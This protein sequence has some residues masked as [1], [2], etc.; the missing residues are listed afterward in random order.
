MSEP[1]DFEAPTTAAFRAWVSL[2]LSATGSKATIVSKETGASVNS[3]GQFLRDSER[4]ISLGR[5]A[6]IERHL[7]AK[8]RAEGKSL[9]PIADA[10]RLMG[11]ADV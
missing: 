9:P 3:L 7:R 1:L 6:S 8:A 5:A 2:A 10:A 11:V 4:E